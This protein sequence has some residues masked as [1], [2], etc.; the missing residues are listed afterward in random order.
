[1]TVQTIKQINP[2]LIKAFMQSVQNVLSTMV[3]VDCRIGKP[4]LKH[5]PKP[6]YD[7]SGI[8]G[9]SGEVVGSVVISFVAD[10][11]TRIVE[12]FTC[13]K[14]PIESPDFADAVGEL[15]NMIA[16]NAKKDF[17]LNA[18]ISIPNVIIGH[19]HTIA[20]L[21]DVPCVIVPCETD[22]GRFS[23]EINIKQV[24]GI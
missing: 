18:S 12:S 2:S 17:G 23:V 7:V 24:S 22:L 11:A 10:T 9:F 20:R 13:E 19:D 5:E 8:V 21:S 15:S 16:G 4:T 6:S 1:M 14:M 3:G